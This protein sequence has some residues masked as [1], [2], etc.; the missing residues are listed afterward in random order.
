M[1]SGITNPTRICNQPI[2]PVV[3]GAATS[4]PAG[5]TSELGVGVAADAL[6]VGVAAVITGVEALLVVAVVGAGTAI[7]EMMTS[8]KT[9][10]STSVVTNR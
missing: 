3:R 7:K 9:P 4:A 10:R 6:V 5:L 8:A 2:T 1:T